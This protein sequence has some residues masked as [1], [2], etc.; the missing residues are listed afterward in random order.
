M[1]RGGFYLK[2]YFT[3]FLFLV[4]IA[5]FSV[6]SHGDLEHH[7]PLVIQEIELADSTISDNTQPSYGEGKATQII[8]SALQLE[9]VLNFTLLIYCLAH[10]IKRMSVLSPVFYQANYLILSSLKRTV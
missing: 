9:L 2:K 4:V 3:L 10:C 8:S 6:I 1:K 5:P 7:N